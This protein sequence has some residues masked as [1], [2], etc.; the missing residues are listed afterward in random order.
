MFSFSSTARHQPHP[1]QVSDLI[2]RKAE[3]RDRDAGKPNPAFC[4][5]VAETIAK[6]NPQIRIAIHEKQLAFGDHRSDAIASTA[7]WVAPF[8][9]PSRPR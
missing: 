7:P 8:Q 4:N 5:T 1:D 6:T 9:P 3:A 2:D